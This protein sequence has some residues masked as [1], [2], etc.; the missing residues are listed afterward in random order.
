MESLN[1]NSADM[2]ATW[3]RGFLLAA[4]CL[5][6][7]VIGTGQTAGQA[8]DAGGSG[9]Q[10]AEI[11]EQNA[12]PKFEQ[13]PAEELREYVSQMKKL[14]PRTYH[15]EAGK[16]DM[17]FITPVVI[18]YKEVEEERRKAKWSERNRKKGRPDT[19]APPL[20]YTGEFYGWQK[21]AKDYSKVVTL[22]AIPEL[23]RTGSWWAASIAAGV[24]LG[25]VGQAFVPLSLKF[26][27]N[28]DRMELWRGGK[29]IEPL[30]A[31]R[32]AQEVSQGSIDD[33]AY[34]GSYRY[35]VSAFAP[36]AR[37][38]VKVWRAGKSK[39]KVAKVREFVRNQVW[40]DFENF[41][42]VKR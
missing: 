4:I 32:I 1:N 39:P 11:S 8:V 38:E 22:Q 31:E 20:L 12:E 6:M 19:P 17:Q 15:V 35:P 25:P 29:K 21:Y 28:F 3:H 16:F 23:K 9:D 5:C 42:S 33:A 24:L 10:A 41:S 13:L 34:F 37:L 14:K 7:S 2:S 26:K 30:S 36:G 40:S 18:A 27:A